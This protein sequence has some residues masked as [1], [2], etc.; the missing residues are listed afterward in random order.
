MGKKLLL[1]III[2]F[3]TSFLYASDLELGLSYTPGDVLKTDEDRQI[4]SVTG[5]KQNDGILG[6]HAGY[7]F[8]WL[9]Y[10]S[11]DSLVVPPWFVQKLSTYEKG[12]GEFHQGIMAPGFITFVDF[13]IRPK[14]KHLYLLATIGINSLYIH[15]EYDDGE[16]TLSRGGQR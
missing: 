1:I 8:W 9:F 16:D 13:G 5:R 7:S 12:N 6:F 4:E 11:S 2:T 14:F 15:S 3:F 10:V